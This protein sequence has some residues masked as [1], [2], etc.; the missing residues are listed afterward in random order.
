MKGECACYPFGLE[1]LVLI[2]WSWQKPALCMEERGLILP[3]PILQQWAAQLAIPSGWKVPERVVHSSL[4][5]QVPSFPSD[6]LAVPLNFLFYF[7]NVIMC[8]PESGH[9]AWYA[10]LSPRGPA[11]LSSWSRHGDPDWSVQDIALE[12]VKVDSV[13]QWDFVIFWRMKSEDTFG[14]HLPFTF[15][16]TEEWLQSSCSKPS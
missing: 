9:T 15:C 1:H 8:L 16:S 13:V 11:F 4:W 14:V 7:C 12:K 3:W 6:A 10:W 2:L 5:T